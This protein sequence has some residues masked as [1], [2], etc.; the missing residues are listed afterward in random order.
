MVG[1][2]SSLHSAIGNWEFTKKHANTAQAIVAISLLHVC[3]ALCKIKVR[4]YSNIA[5]RVLVS[6]WGFGWDGAWCTRQTV[7]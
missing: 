6:P 5:Q 1:S 2:H 4:F 3:T 7:F